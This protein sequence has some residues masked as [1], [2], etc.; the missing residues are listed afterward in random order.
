[1]MKHARA[2]RKKASS[3]LSM[4]KEYD[5]SQNAGV[6]AIL[7]TSGSKNDDLTRKLCAGRGVALYLLPDSEAR[8]FFGH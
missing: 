8:G 3:A 2:A 1:M 6:T 7:A 5:V 4:S